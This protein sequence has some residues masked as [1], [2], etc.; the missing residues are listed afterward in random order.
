MLY[1]KDIF[2]RILHAESEFGLVPFCEVLVG[3]M[4]PNLTTIK[5]MGS[6][7]DSSI[8]LPDHNWYVSFFVPFDGIECPSCLVSQ[9]VHSFVEVTCGADV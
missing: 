5:G 4:T 1:T 6:M 7:T 8:F 3:E 9:I 2:S